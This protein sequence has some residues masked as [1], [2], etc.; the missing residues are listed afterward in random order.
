M[1]EDGFLNR[2]GR[3]GNPGPISPPISLSPPRHSTACNTKNQ[4]RGHAVEGGDAS[5]FSLPSALQSA[6]TTMQEWQDVEMTTT[7]APFPSFFISS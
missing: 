2:T 1:W 5:L 6:T 4:N 7:A 3:I